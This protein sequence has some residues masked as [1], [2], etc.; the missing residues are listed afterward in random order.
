M[1]PAARIASRHPQSRP[2][3]NAGLR[4]AVSHANGDVRNVGINRRRCPLNFPRCSARRPSRRQLPRRR[5]ATY[6]PANGTILFFITALVIGCPSARPT[7]VI[8]VCL[9]ALFILPDEA[10]SYRRSG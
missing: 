5:A 8:T 2:A 6:L 10:A 9:R 4:R 7:A 1:A 3:E